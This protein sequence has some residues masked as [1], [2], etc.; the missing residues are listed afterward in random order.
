MKEG[1]WPERI[2]PNSQRRH[3]TICRDWPWP[4]VRRIDR[5]PASYPSFRPQSAGR[6]AFPTLSS[7]S[8]TAFP[9]SVDQSHIRASSPP[10]GVPALSPLGAQSYRRFFHLTSARSKPQMVRSFLLQMQ[11]MR[12][13]R[14]HEK[15]FQPIS[16]Q[17]L[18][19]APIP[20]V[21]VS[22]SHDALPRSDAWHL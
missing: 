11:S 17:R 7:S 14:H 19:G 2:R 1:R 13:T 10:P 16:G 21:A 15:L 18:P 5:C 3:P 20:P 22:T 6:P 8:W 12:H 4:L 9:A